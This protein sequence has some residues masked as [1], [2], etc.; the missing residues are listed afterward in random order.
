M[1]ATAA[2]LP[3][4]KFIEATS[5]HELPAGLYTKARLDTPPNAKSWPLA[6]AAAPWLLTMGSDAA[7]DHV[8]DCGL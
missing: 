2:V 4:S 6:T 3:C 5:D 7:V 1:T 8:L